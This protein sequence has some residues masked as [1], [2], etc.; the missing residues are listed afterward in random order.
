MTVTDAPDV[1]TWPDLHPAPAPGGVAARIAERLFRSAVGRLDVTV[2]IRGGSGRAEEVIGRG[3]PAIV[4]HR[5]AELF[6]R[7]GRDHLIGFGEAYLTGAWSEDG[8]PGDGVLGDFLAVLAA[9]MS[10]LVPEPLQRLRAFVVPR[11]PRSQRGTRENT[12]ANVAH[13]Y[14]LSNDLFAAFLDPTLSYSSALFTDPAS[15]GAGDLVA[16]QHRKIDRLLDQAGVGPGTRLLEIGTGWG[17]LAI[18]A[19][20]RGA[21]VRSI[22]LSVE[23]QQLAEQRIAAAGH[24]AQVVVDLCDYRALLDEPG[25]SYDAVVS[26]EMIEA[27]GAEFWP[28]YFRTLDHVLVPGGKVALQ[29]ITLPHERMLATRSTHTF[30]TKYI[31]PGGALPSV[32]AIEEVTARHTGL[33]V[34]DDLAIGQHYATTLRL[35]DEAFVAAAEEVGAL[36]F[37]TTFARM[38]HFYLEY[39]RAGFAAGYIDDHQ[40]TLTKDGALR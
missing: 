36:G 19:A 28:T 1:R 35:W 25:A 12:Q 11:L 6:A 20:A 15:A 30:I 23:Q 17:E 29:A 14:D 4:V 34:S 10:S 21:Q 39:C 7:V 38:W 2:R 27:V 24:A 8:V 16:A 32:R 18:R 13:H 5:P 37:D 26:V 9:E 40:L 33:R 31:F 22:T 3:G